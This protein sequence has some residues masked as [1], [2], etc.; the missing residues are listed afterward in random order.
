M[1]DCTSIGNLASVE[2]DSQHLYCCALD[3]VCGFSRAVDWVY[4]ADSDMQ[5]YLYSVDTI[6]WPKQPLNRGF[7]QM[8]GRD[9][10][11]FVSYMGIL[12]RA[13]PCEKV[14]PC[15]AWDHQGCGCRSRQADPISPRNENMIYCEYWS[16]GWLESLPCCQQ[17]C[18]YRLRWDPKAY[19]NV[20]RLRI[21]S[22]VVWRPDI[23]LENK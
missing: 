18:D 5:R 20:T 6:P 16:N 3:F 2:R 12:E 1:W 15:V 23:I 22:T 9:W 19:D 14:H 8:N 13:S 21:P 17:W 7:K 11:T 10:G 4:C